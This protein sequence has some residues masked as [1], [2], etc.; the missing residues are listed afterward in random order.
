MYCRYVTIV[1]VNSPLERACV[2]IGANDLDRL[3]S[4]SVRA[5]DVATA[6]SV[7]V[8][9]AQTAAVI[10]VVSEQHMQSVITKDSA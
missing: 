10:R 6:G 9:D 1:C 4:Q 3:L 5:I 2:S 8:K 7:I